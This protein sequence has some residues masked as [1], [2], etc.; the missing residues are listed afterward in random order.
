MYFKPILV[1]CRSTVHD[2]GPTPN[3]HCGLMHVLCW[4]RIRQKL[5]QMSIVRQAQMSIPPRILDPT[6]PAEVLKIISSHSFWKK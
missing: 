3:Q 5:A 2:A 1:F 4:I 6:R